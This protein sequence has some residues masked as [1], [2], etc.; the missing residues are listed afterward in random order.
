VC[1]VALGRRARGQHDVSVI[2]HTSLAGSPVALLLFPVHL[3]HRVGRRVPWVSIHTARLF[4]LPCMALRSRPVPAYLSASRVVSMS[5][6]CAAIVP[7]FLLTRLAIAS[8]NPPLVQP[9]PGTCAATFHHLTNSFTLHVLLPVLLPSSSS[10]TR[11]SIVFCPQ[12]PISTHPSRVHRG[13]VHHRNSARH[14]HC[15]G[16]IS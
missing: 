5:I 1:T 15:A 14:T 8:R 6:T 13:L 9:T 7:A 3:C 12:T 4:R 11:H 16:A 2:R 10:T